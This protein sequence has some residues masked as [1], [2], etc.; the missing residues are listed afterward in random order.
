MFREKDVQ[1]II[2]ANNLKTIRRHIRVGKIQFPQLQ[3]IARKMD[4]SVLRVCTEKEKKETPLMDVF[5]YML[6]TWY[7][8]VLYKPDVDGFKALIEI[9][10]DEEVGLSSLALNMV[11]LQSEVIEKTAKETKIISQ[12]N[13]GQHPQIDHQGDKEVCVSIA[14]SKVLCFLL[15]NSYIK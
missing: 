3:T 2:G 15:C 14:M 8:E 5:N 7:E 11:P 13:Y 10:D 1:D 12:K 6:D 9:L 4:G